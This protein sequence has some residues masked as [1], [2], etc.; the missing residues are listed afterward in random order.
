MNRLHNEALEFETE[1]GEDIPGMHSPRKAMRNV[2]SIQRRIR[3]G[4]N[5]VRIAAG[6]AE[7]I[8]KNKAY[9]SANH[10]TGLFAVRFILRTRN[11]TIDLG[12]KGSPQW[13]KQKAFFRSID[14]TFEGGMR[15]WRG[16][17][18]GE[19]EAFIREHLVPV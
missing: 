14:P 10:R 2:A 5:T 15:A 9:N 12:E 1:E 7:R 11:L 6:A 8:I 19:I 18:P 13:H 16:R 4:Q 17:S 3:L